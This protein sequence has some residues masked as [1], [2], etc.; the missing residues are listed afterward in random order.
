MEVIGARR[1]IGA[2][3]GCSWRFIGAMRGCSWSL[4]EL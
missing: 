3:R 1:F 2:M 4:L